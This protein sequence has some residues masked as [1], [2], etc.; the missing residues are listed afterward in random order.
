MAIHHGKSHGRWNRFR[1]ASVAAALSLGGAPA[2]GQSCHVLPPC[3]ALVVTG[4]A[5]AAPAGAPPL[6]TAAPVALAAPPPAAAPAAPF[7]SWARRS[8]RRRRPR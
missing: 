4:S 1:P 5:P 3:P 2:W 7:C 6:F 8:P